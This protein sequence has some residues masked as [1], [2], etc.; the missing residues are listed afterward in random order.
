MIKQHFL[1][2]IHLQQNNI[3]Y[4]IKKHVFSV[5]K[6]CLSNNLL[7]SIYLQQ[8]SPTISTKLTTNCNKKYVCN[9]EKVIKQTINSPHIEM[10]QKSPTTSTNITSEHNKKNHVFCT[11]IKLVKQ[12]SL[13]FILIYNKNRQL[14]Q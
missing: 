14:F 8:T 13:C 2:Q 7:L 4:F 3:N 5:I 6:K 12:E 10:Q 9:N 1:L 11:N